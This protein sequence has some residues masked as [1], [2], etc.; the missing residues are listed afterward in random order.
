MLK[1]YDI[2][3]LA[4]DFIDISSHI[5]PVIGDG[6]MYYNCDN[7]QTIP[8]LQYIINRFQKDFPQIQIPC[9]NRADLFILTCI[10][11]EIDTSVFEGKY[12]RYINDA[13]KA[14]KIELDPLVLDFL[15]VFH[16]PVIITTS[17]F[18]YIEE[19]INKQL[20]SSKYKPVIY[21]PK[22]NNSNKLDNSIYHLFG[23]A[24]DRFSDWVYNEDVLLEFLHNLHSS[25][26]S[27][28]NLREY[29][30]KSKSTMMILG[31]D[32]SDWLF[33]FLWYR[34]GYPE[35]ER[36][37]YWLNNNL[38]IELSYF[39]KNI[40]YSSINTVNEFLTKTT[41]LKR[42]EIAEEII[43]DKLDQYDLFISYAGE[44]EKIAKK[45]Y[46]N[47]QAMG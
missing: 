36:T 5:I 21:N 47:I 44:D 27:C 17:C 33:R 15:T 46:E 40:S 29:I 3:K 4:S 12:V 18:T 35:K 16:F 43:Y 2:D 31:C 11:H 10:S 19:A 24:E 37:G 30:I 41:A 7:D 13:R 1:N 20:S 32:L 34:M 23:N 28:K 39:L 6:A 25:D 26:H 14:K 22:D 9:N 38:N 42:K 8:L 45:L